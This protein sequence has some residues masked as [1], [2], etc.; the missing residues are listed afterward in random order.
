MFLL[1]EVAKDFEDRMVTHLSE[2][3]PDECAA[4]RGTGLRLMIQRGI[5][6]AASYKITKEYEVCLY[7][8]LMFA[9]GEDFDKNANFSWALAI[10]D[11]PDQ[12]ATPKVERVYD[13]A[14]EIEE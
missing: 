10:L 7:L 2:V 6:R 13:M 4:L 12:G 11:A 3:F 1:L 5:L 14:A 9:L 8:H